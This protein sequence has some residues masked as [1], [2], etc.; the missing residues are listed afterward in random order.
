MSIAM[1][2]GALE[3]GDRDA[4]RAVEGGEGGRSAVEMEGFC[5][6]C[7]YGGFLGFGV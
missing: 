1:Y 4:R 5:F 7:F 2:R 3:G 6:A